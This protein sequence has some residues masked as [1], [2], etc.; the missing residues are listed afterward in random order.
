MELDPEDGARSMRDGHDHVVRTRRVHLEIV[1]K[2][3]AVDDERMVA[4]RPNRLRASGEEAFVSVHDVGHLA[5]HWHR[6]ANDACAKC[7]ADRLMS[8]ADAEE[9]DVGVGADEVEDA[10]SA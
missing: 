6:S 9:R 5:M 10:A 7:L 1:W 3:C 8:K 4:G 2:C